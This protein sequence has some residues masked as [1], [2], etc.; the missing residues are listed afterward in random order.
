MEKMYQQYKDVAEFY[1]V[2]IS[3]AHAQDDSWPVPYAKDLVIKEHTTYGERCG[4]ADKLAKVPEGDG[5]MLDNTLIVYLSDN[6][7]QHHASNLQWPIVVVGNL[8]GALQST[9]RYIAYPH[10]NTGKGVRTIGNFLTTI[11]QRAGVPQDYFGQP[12]LALGPLSTQTGPLNE[13]L[14]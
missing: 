4:L 12:D 10:Y 13:L 3:E 1:I 7:D 2:Y 9:G 8:N 11:T 14:A 6:A 5:S